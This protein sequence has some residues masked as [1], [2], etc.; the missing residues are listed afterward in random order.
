MRATHLES[1]LFHCDR[2]SL[3]ALM[4]DPSVVSA[5]DS[6]PLTMLSLTGVTR[7]VINA[8]QSMHPLRIL[9]LFIEPDIETYGPSNSLPIDLSSLLTGSAS[10]LEELALVNRAPSTIVQNLFGMPSPSP[11]V[12]PRVRSL[13]WHVNIHPVVSPAELHGA[14]P[15][16]RS[17]AIDP[18]S[19]Y[20][21]PQSSDFSQST[22]NVHP[23]AIRGNGH[24]VVA[25]TRLFEDS[26][27]ENRVVHAM[28]TTLTLPLHPRD[29]HTF[30]FRSLCLPAAVIVP[31]PKIPKEVVNKVEFLQV[32]DIPGTEMMPPAKFVS[33]RFYYLM[34]SETVQQLRLCFPERI[35]EI[36]LEK[37]PAL[38][39]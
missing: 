37:F 8:I 2:T 10:T 31:Y 28:P 21:P 23:I 25:Y 7:R 9:R 35:F 3:I 32:Y 33:I 19:L 15:A 34:G 4:A 17:L 6:Y 16:L 26:D 11:I 36:C 24:A 13:T 27:A 20:S 38:P 12:F 39:R 30:R 29:I 5:L 1:F 22:T 14:F 18:P